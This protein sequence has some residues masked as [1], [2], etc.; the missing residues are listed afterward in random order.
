MRLNKYL[1]RCGVG[2]RRQCDEHILKGKVS[3]DDE[4]VKNPAYEVEAGQVVKYNKKTVTL[5]KGMTYLLMNKPKNISC[6]YDLN[7]EKSISKILKNKI[8]HELTV[9]AQLQLMDRGLILLTDDK[10]VIDKFKSPEKG[11]QQSYEVTLS[12]DVTDEDIRHLSVGKRKDEVL[13]QLSEIS[14]VKDKGLNMLGFK[15]KQLDTAYFHKVFE[16]FGH[17]VEI[18]DRTY[19]AGLTKKDLPR[20]FF[21]KLTDKESIFLKHFF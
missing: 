7:D 11:L 21:R 19:L 15:S 4:V 18:L 5:R 14:R 16:V 3:I 12:K 20:G 6:T 2:T 17:E 1:A 13:Y 10:T 8:P 9:V